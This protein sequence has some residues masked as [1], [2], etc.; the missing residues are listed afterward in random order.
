MKLNK[1]EIKFIT[2][3]FSK[4]ADKYSWRK[5]IRSRVRPV[6]DDYFTASSCHDLHHWVLKA[7]VEIPEGTYEFE[8]RVTCQPK[9]YN[10]NTENP[11]NRKNKI[12]LSIRDFYQDTG[13]I[14]VYDFQLK[15]SSKNIYY[16]LLKEEFIKLWEFAVYCRECER[17][18]KKDAQKRF[19]KF[20]VNS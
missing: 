7:T 16:N 6:Y 15:S 9:N 3:I 17:T 13:R 11:F 2:K 20:I 12:S 10:D 8:F 14:V 4:I 5:Y 1:E 18:S 19:N